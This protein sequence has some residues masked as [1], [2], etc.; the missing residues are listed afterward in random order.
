MSAITRPDGS[1][2]A[3]AKIFHWLTVPLMVGA[4]ATG[5]VIGFIRDSSKFDFYTIHES[6]GFTLLLVAIARIIWRRL[7]P[8]PPLPDHLPAN[9]RLAANAVHHAL[10]AALIIQP[11]LG[12]FGA[13]AWGFPM[14]GPTAYLGFI[15][16]PTIMPKMEWLGWLL[17]ELHKYLGWAI[18]PLLLAHIAG[19]IYHHAIRR[20]GT[21][22]RM[23]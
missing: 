23:V 6:I 4:I 9:M 3:V 13:N 19:A 18:I 21:L 11:V 2:G 10:Y 8:P 14:A 15:N 1:Y 20:D 5:C 7:S 17:L 22:M 16:F 12:F